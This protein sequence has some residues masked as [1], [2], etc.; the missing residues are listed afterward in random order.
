MPPSPAE[1]FC[2]I[3]LRFEMLKQLVFLDLTFDSITWEWTASNPYGDASTSKD[4][5]FRFVIMNHHQIV[6]LWLI[7]NFLVVSHPI[8]ISTS[9]VWLIKNRVEQVSMTDLVKILY[10][11]LSTPG[12]NVIGHLSMLALFLRLVEDLLHQPKYSFIKEHLF[13]LIWWSVNGHT[14]DHVLTLNLHG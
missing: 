3:L 1:Y 8:S 7:E 13:R 4:L 11:N 10:N 2:S 5:W 12:M 6:Q 14:F 9:I